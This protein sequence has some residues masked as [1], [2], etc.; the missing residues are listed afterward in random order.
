MLIH[1]DMPP[2]GD[3]CMPADMMKAASAMVLDALMPLLL[4]MDRVAARRGDVRIGLSISPVLADILSSDTFARFFNSYSES[5]ARMIS[6]DLLAFARQGRGE[7]VAAA[8]HWL[9]RLEETMARYR[10]VGGGMLDEFS[11]YR[12]VELAASTA[13]GAS[14]ALA[15]AACCRLQTETGL[16]AFRRSAGRRA[17]GLA[18]RGLAAVEVAGGT[19]G[20]LGAEGVE[21]VAD[22]DGAEAARAGNVLFLPAARLEPERFV[23]HGRSYLGMEAVS[24]PG[25]MRYTT[26]G[27]A[28]YSRRRAEEEAA[29]EAEAF[30]ASLPEGMHL[31]C[32]DAGSMFSVWHEADI[33]LEALLTGGSGDFAATPGQLAPA[34]TEAAELAADS[35]GAVLSGAGGVAIPAALAAEIGGGLAPGMSAAS[36]QASRE[37]IL[38]H[39]MAWWNHAGLARVNREAVERHTARMEQLTAGEADVDDSKIA[40][41]REETPYMDWLDRRDDSQG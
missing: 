2:T 19:A 20:V 16:A 3:D 40:V 12:G 26:P 15:D 38:I 33:W 25:G 17:A 37:A 34:C 21:W 9:D 36:A 30:A 18:A 41:W 27:G 13:T 5:R 32:I 24:V 29:A 31:F 35:G 4:M 14:L 8:N 1:A 23:G 6:D 10:S 22:L 39:T 11:A 7:H 28:A